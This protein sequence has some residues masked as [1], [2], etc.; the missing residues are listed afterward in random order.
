MRRPANCTVRAFR[1]KTEPEPVLQ[2]I[3]PAIVHSGLLGK[4]PMQHHIQYSKPSPAEYSLPPELCLPRN[5]TPRSARP[6]TARPPRPP[7]P[8]STDNTLAP[9]IPA[10]VPQTSRPELSPP[11]AVD[12]PNIFYA[13]VLPAAEPPS[14]SNFEQ[15]EE[16]LERLIQ[17][18]P[19]NPSQIFG[20]VFG[21][22]I[23]QYH[24]ECAG[25]GSILDECRDF[26]TKAIDNIPEIEK[27]YRDLINSMEKE[28]AQ[29][30]IAIQAVGPIIEQAEHKKAYLATVVADLRR[31]LK[32]L[33]DHHDS[34]I[35]NVVVATNELNEIK[36][37]LNRLDM[38]TQKKNE[39]LMHMINQ[40]RVMTDIS[41]SYTTDTLRFAENLKFLR[42]QQEEGRTEIEKTSKVVKDY[43]QNIARY[44]NQIS[45][46]A[47]NIEQSRI[48]PQLADLAV[49]VDLITRRFF[50]EQR[51][52]ILPSR[53][54]TSVTAMP[55]SDDDLMKRIATEFALS[56]GRSG[57]ARQI[58]VTSYE[59]YAKLRRI[60]FKH[61]D[62][63]RIPPEAIAD[64]ETG[65]IRL[66]DADKDHL[67]LFVA[68][69]I[70]SVLY[71]AARKKPAH[72]ILTQTL[73]PQPIPEAGNAHFQRI[74]K[75]SRFI[76][77]VGI[78][79]SRR[80]PRQFSWLLETINAIYEEK[81]A[82][83]EKALATGSPLVPL[84][85][86]VIKY[87]KDQKKLQ[88]LAD[89]FCWDIH[90]TAH[91]HNG[92]APP[93]D[94]FVS[95]LDEQFS[96]EQL[97][98]FLLC[99][100][101]C[102]KVGSAVTVTTRDQ[103]ETYNEY[104][105]SDDQVRIALEI[106][107]KDRNRLEFFNSII[108][109]SVSRPAVHLE[110][111]KKYVGMHDILLSSVL[112][113]ADD[114]LRKLR[115]C[116]AETRI[117]P[118]LNQ[119]HFNRLLKTLIPELTEQDLAEFHKATV[120]QGKRRANVP[121]QAFVQKFKGNSV[122]RNKRGGIEQSDENLDVF[123]IV[124]ER[125]QAT[126]LDLGNILDFFESHAALEPDNLTLKVLLDDAVR[127]H[128]NL[129]HSM[130]Y[131]RGTL[132]LMQYYQ[133]MFSLD[134]LFSTLSV[135]KVSP[136]TLLSMECSARENWLEEVF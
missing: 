110:A 58:L 103:V 118:R 65:N 107:W 123:N 32:V 92:R 134:V 125:W 114:K 102:L 101:D 61:E 26:F 97:A 31:D 120:M 90:I 19:M 71:R 52:E 100:S 106:W 104:F 126:Q 22:V 42:G 80:N 129:V 11:K 51:R 91:E 12:G 54:M 21:E 62:E 7:Q 53:S 33:V 8:S 50:K 115:E 82:D 10:H 5:T 111:T 121:V 130:S 3:E 87:A 28:I 63:F 131:R 75:E 41:S 4:S 18:Q 117:T 81:R 6:R 105:V 25:Q 86:Y 57:V 96:T 112:M 68:S 39:K 113:Y 36:A 95:F 2:D 124:L 79:Y 89:Q 109:C 60:L 94:M 133:F 34:V 56:T 64:M 135:R 85:E 1:N 23:R 116:L 55:Q 77:L 40:L 122:L 99:R 24:M 48:E 17:E 44:D 136:E 15:L 29:H 43:R 37:R 59:E 49:Q 108:E 9:D 38:R 66:Q 73:T 45:R 70:D 35:R 69:M 83:D 27:H 127:H 72:E 88:F 128:S 67:R 47:D 74:A 98:F 16:M 30:R 84:P 20:H 46:L 14:S 76:S 93:A 119:M 132:C 13:K 78:D